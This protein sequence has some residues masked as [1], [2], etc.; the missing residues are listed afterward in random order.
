MFIFLEFGVDPFTFNLDSLN[1][2]L[3]CE[4]FLNNLAIIANSNFED[5]ALAEYQLIL[6]ILCA[7]AFYFFLFIVVCESLPSKV[8]KHKQF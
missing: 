4:S 2:C 3:L 8:E 5:S 6:I 1:Y 7:I